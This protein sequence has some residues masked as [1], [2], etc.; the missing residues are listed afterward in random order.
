MMSFFRGGQPLSSRLSKLQSFYQGESHIWD[1]GCD[2]GLLGLSFSHHPEVKSI[3]LVDPSALVID[4]LNKKL[5]DSYIS[6]ATIFH[7]HGQKIKIKS[8]S[9]CIFI[10]GMGGKEVGE[11]ILHLLPQLEPDSKFVISPH[12]KIMEL[13]KLLSELPLGLKC[14]EVLIEDKQFY[15][16]LVLVPG[17]GAPI[18]PYGKDIWRGKEGRE[19]LDHQIRYLSV[20]RDEASLEYLKYLK[21]LKLLNSTQKP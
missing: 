1:I 5:K 8:P 21:N 12:R 2:H 6:N 14:E 15:Q 10:A 13:R 16:M 11:I 3:N 20:H 17:K 18:H 4:V 7:E 9:N 19:Y